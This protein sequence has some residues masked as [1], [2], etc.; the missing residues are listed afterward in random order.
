MIDQLLSH[1]TFEIYEIVILVALFILLLVRL[2]FYISFYYKSYLSAK[3]KVEYTA[4]SQQSSFPKVSV[5]I[6]SENEAIEL[7]KN[8]PLILT[9]DYP[10]YEV[11]VVNN[12]STDESDD[13]LQ[14]LKLTYPNLYFT[15]VLC[16][17]SAKCIK[18]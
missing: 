1:F 7:S 6:A 9:Q 10:N 5:V 13:L 18:K 11:I 3:K 8:L 17:S 4:T 16:I 15:Y 12:G 2:F 14:S